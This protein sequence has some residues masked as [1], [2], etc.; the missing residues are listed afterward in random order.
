[1]AAAICREV[2]PTRNQ[3]PN[4][5]HPKSLHHTKMHQAVKLFVHDTTVKQIG[6]WHL[7]PHDKRR[8]ATNSPATSVFAACAAFGP[9]RETWT[10][11][12]PPRPAN[13][14]RLA[15][16]HDISLDRAGARLHEGQVHRGYPVPW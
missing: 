3:S 4:A 13:A 9:E 10:E 2:F 16:R 15:N 14:A 12:H 8:R 6:L 1:M 7:M 11:T 5:A